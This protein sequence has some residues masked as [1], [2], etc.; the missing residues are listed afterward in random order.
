MVSA[1]LRLKLC[2]RFKRQ[3]G[4]SHTLLQSSINEEC[5]ELN[6]NLFTELLLT[7]I[8]SF[9]IAFILRSKSI[10]ITK[11]NELQLI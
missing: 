4:Y 7:T 11:S 6:I 1:L 8:R 9:D 10:H 3:Q 2:T 5:S